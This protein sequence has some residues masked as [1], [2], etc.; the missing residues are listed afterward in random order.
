MQEH[1]RRQRRHLIALGTI[2]VGTLSCA[3]S[4]STAP[5][6]SP[7][8]SSAPRAEVSAGAPVF[9]RGCVE[10]PENPLAVVCDGRVLFTL[11]ASASMCELRATSMA[12]VVGSQL[13]SPGEDQIMAPAAPLKTAEGSAF[14][15][16]RIQNAAGIDV[17]MIDKIRGPEG[18]AFASA[19]CVRPAL[20]RFEARCET[21]L[22]AVSRGAVTLTAFEKLDP[23]LAEE[24]VPL[25]IADRPF[26]AGEH[27]QTVDVVRGLRV[28][29]IEAPI[30]GA[31]LG[32]GK[33][34][35][36]WTTT[37]T[38]KEALALLHAPAPDGPRTSRSE[39]CVVE[40]VPT[41][42][43]HWRDRDAAEK[44]SSHL[45]EGFVRVR[46]QVVFA[47]CEWRGE[48]SIPPPCDRVFQRTP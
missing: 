8:A 26:E 7:V 41:Q 30:K 9:F 1:I 27:C 21:L 42:C 12:M 4:S 47:R 33:A 48:N 24:T 6:T 10:L 5:S 39:A 2:L 29:G 23:D 20:D 40:G 31:K 22:D 13:F 18:N 14:E 37:A 16:Q 28:Q 44:T 32:C 17:V 19:V 43:A 35:L 38:L 25:T 15:R 3:S 34:T 45:F 36:S 11:C 46:D